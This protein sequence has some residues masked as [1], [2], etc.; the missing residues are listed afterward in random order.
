MD[1]LRSKLNLI[2]KMLME[3]R[4]SRRFVCGMMVIISEQC[5]K[6]D[7]LEIVVTSF[8]RS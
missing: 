4:I 1:G 2:L 5:V 6:S 7:Y 8:P 3:K